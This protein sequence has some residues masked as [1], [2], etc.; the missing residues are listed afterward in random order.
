LILD[1]VHIHGQPVLV[2]FVIERQCEER[3]VEFGGKA[4]KMRIRLI[5][6]STLLMTYGGLRLLFDP[7]L[8]AKGE[9]RSYAGIFRSPLVDLPVPASDVVTNLDA[10]LVS[11]LH[12]DHFDEAACT[13]LSK[14]IPMLCHSRDA[15]EIRQHGF[16]RV[17]GFEQAMTFGDVTL[18][19]IA[20]Q[21]GPPEVREDLGEVSGFVLRHPQEPTLYLV[22]D[23]ILCKPVTKA[24]Q[25]HTPEV[26]VVH[27][28]GA[29]WQGYAP[30]VMDAEQVKQV[31]ALS[32]QANVLAT[33]LDTVDHATETRATLRQAAG[34]LPLHMSR[35]LHIP[36]DGEET[37]FDL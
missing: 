1:P 2:D 18:T 21:H 26:I 4:P 37:V 35:R 19:A 22:G 3:R 11:H 27:A 7:Y 34:T 30:V 20:G 25:E 10:V 13:H 12:S 36:N 33:H 9:G 14:T 31:L 28:A 16:T 23:S 8:A 32:L 24:I 6:S 17:S 5:R 15:Q 29:T